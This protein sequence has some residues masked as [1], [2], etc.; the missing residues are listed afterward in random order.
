MKHKAVVCGS[1]L[2]CKLFKAEALKGTD[3]ERPWASD[4][5]R[6]PCRVLF[7]SNA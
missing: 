7:A 4:I 5:F 3:E 2:V 6:A 1:E